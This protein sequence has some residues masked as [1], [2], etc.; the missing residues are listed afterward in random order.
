MRVTLAQLEA[1]YW[2]AKP[3][4]ATRAARDLNLAQP[5]LSLR[6]KSLVDATGGGP[7]LSRTSGT[8]R[9]KAQGQALLRAAG[10][11]TEL[12][13]IDMPGSYPPSSWSGLWTRIWSRTAASSVHSSSRSNRVAGSPGGSL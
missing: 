9:L 10:V 4:S 6:L 12:Q 5:T 13:G 7:L 2:T 1:F 11:M 8:S 3:G